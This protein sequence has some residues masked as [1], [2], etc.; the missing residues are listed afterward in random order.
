MTTEDSSHIQATPK[1]RCELLLSLLKDHYNGLVAF[2]FKHASLL[3]AAGGWLISSDSAR[4]FLCAEP[5]VRYSLCGFLLLITL[6]HAMGVLRFRVRSEVAFKQLV[7][8]N[9]MPKEYVEFRKISSSTA[10][11]TIATH[12]LISIMILLL[13]LNL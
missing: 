5:V 9:Y 11:S 2:A 4:T 10:T 3:S 7:E 6:L 8:V 13:L 12:I 1:E